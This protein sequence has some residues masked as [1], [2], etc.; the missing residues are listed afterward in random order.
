MAR[1]ERGEQFLVSVQLDGR[2]MVELDETTCLL[3]QPPA[4][5][6]VECES[7]QTNGQS[8]SVTAREEET[9]LAIENELHVAIDV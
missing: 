9:G 3:P 4:K 1:E 7:L 5:S 8:Q 2:G 6:G